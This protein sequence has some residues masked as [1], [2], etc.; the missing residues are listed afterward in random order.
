V[1]EVADDMDRTGIG[2]P[3]A[4]GGATSN[5]VRTHRS[6]GLDMIEG[7][8]HSQCPVYCCNKARATY[9]QAL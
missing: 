9:T 2:R 8:R 3:D 6:A 7:G 1:V 5:E 4:K